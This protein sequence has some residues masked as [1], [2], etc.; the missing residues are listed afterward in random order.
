MSRMRKSVFFIGLAAGIALLSMLALRHVQGDALEQTR[1]DSSYVC[2][3]FGDKVM[4]IDPRY[5]FLSRVEYQ[6]VDYWRQG[7]RKAHDSKGCDDQIQSAAFDVEWP[8]MTPSNSFR[9]MGKPNFISIALNQRS[10]WNVEKRGESKDF[11]DHTELLLLHSRTGRHGSERERSI[12]E[13]N[14]LKKFNTDLGLYDIPGYDDEKSS[15]I[16]YWQ[17]IEGKGISLTIRCV[18]YKLVDEP[19]C[20]YITHV[21]DYGHNTSYLKIYFH[22]DLLPHWKDLHRDA[23]QLIDRFTAKGN[24]R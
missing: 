14:S 2:G 10:V 15:L 22:A 6:D 13:I 18:Y 9:N 3:R 24:G 1:D 21:P 12:D 7:N 4:R 19:A 17:E 5:L 8:A 20:Q 23:L 11:F 16:A